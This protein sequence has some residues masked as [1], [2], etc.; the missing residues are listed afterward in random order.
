MTIRV[1]NLS[2]QPEAMRA[3]Y[4]VALIKRSSGAS[5]A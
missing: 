1:T 3:R 5:A 4:E 2:K